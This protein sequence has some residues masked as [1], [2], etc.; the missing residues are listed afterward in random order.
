MF[1]SPRQGESYLLIPVPPT[2]N[3]RLHL[4]HIAGPYLRMDVLARRLRQHGAQ[5]ALYTGTD[6]HDSYVLWRAEQDDKS[7]TAVC[8]G[9][10]AGIAEDLALMR[11]EVDGFV[12]TLEGEGRALQEDY[13]RDALERLL[14][15]G[16]AVIRAEQIPFDLSTQ[17]AIVGCWLTGHCPSCGSDCAGYFCEGCGTHFRPEQMVDATPRKAHAKV[18]L[19]TVENVFLR[20]PD[21][22][23][24]LE[25]LHAMGVAPEVCD[26][27]ARF[28]A[29]PGNEFRLTV[30]ISWGLAWPAD[31]SGCPRAIFE[32]LWEMFTYGH[33]HA[34]QAGLE[35]HA[36]QRD[37]ATKIVVG[38]G[39]DNTIPLLV[40]GV[41]VLAALPSCKPPAHALTNFFI[42]LEGEKFSTS[43][44]H[45]IWA[46]D[47]ARA[48]DGNVDALRY[49]LCTI[50]PDHGVTN[51]SV[52]QFATVVNHTVAQETMEAVRAAVHQGHAAA[53]DK[54]VSAPDAALI[55]RFGTALAAQDAN[56][57]PSRVTLAPVV[58]EIA[59]WVA[60]TSASA[61][62]GAQAYWW[63][64]AF[65]CLA[66]PVMPQLACA[67]W[68]TL[69]HK[70][71]PWL[72]HFH[73]TPAC[74]D[75]A[76]FDALHAPQILPA[77]L[78]AL[79]PPYLQS[80]HTGK[81]S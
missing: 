34:R 41:G 16:D 5:V 33:L 61:P 35:A 11:I 68:Q 7:P 56:L 29:V 44:K 17:E 42:N 80:T 67:V 26:V 20:I 30:P 55:A 81:E 23:A 70:G 1:P 14:A 48:L 75:L 62:T 38:F 24:H 52:T 57:Q 6:C 79:L 77:Q 31:P 36:W 2:P 37:S 63:A 78:D 50:S 66:Y 40:G 60:D 49:Y 46:A 28:L 19:R 27:V 43:R 45:A 73:D 65:A 18:G 4:G 32:I 64:K 15:S 51:F 3:G 58:Q 22:A 69:G 13:A 21:S 39:I 74:G 71:D 72:K 76:Q 10:H 12:D 54:P 59:A 47:T 53:I 25:R 8:R 9:F